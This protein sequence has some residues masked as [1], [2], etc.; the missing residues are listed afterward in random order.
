[1]KR[2]FYGK[3]KRPT[4]KNLRLETLIEKKLL[5]PGVAPVVA[6]RVRLLIYL[7]GPRGLSSWL[8]DEESPTLKPISVNAR[9][10][11]K[12]E[13]MNREDSE[14]V[15][16]KQKVTYQFEE[17]ARI[18][19]YLAFFFCAVSTYKM[20]LL[21]EFHVSYFD[22]GAALINA[23]VIG[24]VV[25]IGQDV[26]LGKKHEAKPLLVSALSKAFLFSLLVFGFHIVEEIVKRLVHGKNMAGALHDVRIDD[27]LARSVI[28]FCTFIPLFLFL[29]LRRV[30]GDNKFYDLFLRTGA[31]A[32][33][34][35]S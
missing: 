34:D 1:M 8:P 17:L 11:W 23:L 13:L 22:Y 7:P 15:G 16:L 18:S 2:L 5:N 4:R 35:R 20:L 32:K 26:H 29:E 25:L 24:K 33:S 28:I 3:L 19:V 30:L 10:A 14:T 12:G 6:R 27:L 31:T 21:N 9:S